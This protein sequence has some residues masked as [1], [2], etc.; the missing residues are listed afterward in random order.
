M[1]CLRTSV[2]MWN[3]FLLNFSWKDLLMWQVG[4]WRNKP[5]SGLFP[6]CSRQPGLGQVDSHM[7]SSVQSTWLTYCP[8]DALAESWI[9]K[10]SIV[11][12]KQVLTLI[13]CCHRCCGFLAALQCWP[14]IKLSKPGNLEYSSGKCKQAYI[15][16]GVALMRWL[17]CLGDVFI[18]DR[19]HSWGIWKFWLKI[20]I[21]SWTNMTCAGLNVISWCLS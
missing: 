19:E 4:L 8:P 5:F 13:G 1:P 18:C 3:T 21:C 7:G 11:N 9:A 6:Q 16:L 10:W 14:P 17:F 2:I 20:Y 15:P 12:F